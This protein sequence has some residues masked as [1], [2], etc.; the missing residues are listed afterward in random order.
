MKVDGVFVPLVIIGATGLAVT[1]NNIAGAL[2]TA[3]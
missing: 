3:P 2:V 1:V